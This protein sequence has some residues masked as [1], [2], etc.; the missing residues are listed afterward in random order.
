MLRENL[1]DS[2][3]H[4]KS[5]VF[6]AVAGRGELLSVAPLV[7]DAKIWPPPYRTWYERLY[8]P[9]TRFHWSPAKERRAPATSTDTRASYF[10]ALHR[11]ARSTLF[12]D[13][14]TGLTRDGGAR[15]RKVVT[16][17]EVRYLLQ[18][19]RWVAF[20]QDWRDDGALPADN[21]PWPRAMQRRGNQLREQFRR[22]RRIRAVAVHGVRAGIV[23]AS[24]TDDEHFRMV[25]ALKRAYRPTS[26]T[27][28]FT[29]E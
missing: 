9:S 23:F 7:S 10:L 14:S 11:D 8:P 19:R 21:P 2:L 1:G 24:G 25:R 15:S 22:S 18:R 29:I 20:Y 4:L 17:A 5:F 27:R 26:A 12:L 13:A 16:I 3:D 28:V 6:A